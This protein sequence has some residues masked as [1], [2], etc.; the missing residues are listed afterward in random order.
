VS[1]KPKLSLLVPDGDGYYWATH[2]KHGWRDLVRLG[3]NGLRHR[4]AFTARHSSSFDPSDFTDF[5]REV[6]ERPCN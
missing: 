6:K 1:R 3:R 5:S 2:R 4:R